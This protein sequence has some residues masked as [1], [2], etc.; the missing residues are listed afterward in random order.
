MRAEAVGL[1]AALAAALLVAGSAG[2]LVPVPPLR[3]RVNDLAGVLDPAAASRL[4]AALAHRGRTPSEATL[5]EMD[6]LWN[7]AKAAE[8]NFER[9]PG[10]ADPARAGNRDQP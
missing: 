2:A 6:A 7:E 1:A 3:G 8:R 5:A 10:F 4:E 9:Q